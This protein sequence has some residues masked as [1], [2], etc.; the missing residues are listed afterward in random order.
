MHG[1]HIRLNTSS[2]HKK[3]K[4]IYYERSPHQIEYIIANLRK[5]KAYIMNGHHIRL[6]TSSKHK[7]T[8]SIYYER[9]PHQTEYII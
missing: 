1:H 2:K 4:S 6:N 9:S 7:K 8:K 5:Q 3:T